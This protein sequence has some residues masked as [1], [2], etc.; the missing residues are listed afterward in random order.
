MPHATVADYLAALPE[1]RR[2]RLEALGATA[3]AAAPQAAETIAYGMPALRMDGH[4]LV[5][6]SAFK[7]HDSLFPASDEVI[8][9]LGDAV[10][11]YVAGRG[12]FRFPLAEPLP[13]ELI[14][15]I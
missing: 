13:L 5:S 10:T 4:F 15:D 1:A 8:R 11:R 14:A 3:R 7:A 2:G 6:W 9:R 12:T